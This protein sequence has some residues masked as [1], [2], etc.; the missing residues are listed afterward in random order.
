MATDTTG[1]S[2]RTAPY[3]VVHYVRGSIAYN[4]AH[5][6]EATA[7]SIGLIPAGA[8]VLRAHVA[9]TA[10]FNAATTNVILVGSAATN[11]LFVDS[12]DVDEGTIAVTTGIITGTG[13]LAADT[14]VYAKYSQTGTAATTGAATIVIEYVPGA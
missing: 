3:Q 6:G 10:A 11:N 9:V 14:K 1:S 5:I 2:A 8:F 4:T 7:V 12:D 13:L